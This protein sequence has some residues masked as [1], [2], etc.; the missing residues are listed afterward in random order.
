[1]NCS[2]KFSA[3]SQ[4]EAG[5]YCVTFLSILHDN[6]DDSHRM[7]TRISE[8]IGG[9]AV[10]RNRDRTPIKMKIKRLPQAKAQV[11]F[12]SN[13]SK[14]SSFGRTLNNNMD[15]HSPHSEKKLQSNSRPSNIS[16]VESTTISS[17]PTGN[18]RSDWYKKNSHVNLGI[19]NKQQT[20]KISKTLAENNNIFAVSKNKYDAAPVSK[21]NGHLLDLNNGPKKKK[22]R[23]MKPSLDSASPAIG[24]EECDQK[25]RRVIDFDQNK[26]VNANG[27][28]GNATVPIL[29]VK[30]VHETS[31]I[32][33]QPPDNSVPVTAGLK[34][35]VD[36]ADNQINDKKQKKSRFVAP[37][38]RKTLTAIKRSGGKR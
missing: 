7:D 28:E 38:M 33:K 10:D 24:K 34:K 29:P 23:L 4:L 21:V 36:T 32:S 11:I 9:G 35:P 37:L 16:A 2:P 15:L 30:S 6:D 3:L 8:S 17:G 1:M 13:S 25:I 31:Y 14:S 26:K 27:T 18:S 12:K 22:R 5:E 20:L 19:Q